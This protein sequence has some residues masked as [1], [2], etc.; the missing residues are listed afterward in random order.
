MLKRV[1]RGLLIC[2]NVR[3]EI[4]AAVFIHLFNKGIS[5]FARAAYLPV[6]SFLALFSLLW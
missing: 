5:V 2:G 4:L 3:R 6:F 1:L